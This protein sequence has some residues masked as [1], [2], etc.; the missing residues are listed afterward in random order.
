MKFQAITFN[1]L[2]YTT[3]THTHTHK[4]QQNPKHILEIKATKPLLIRITRRTNQK[5]NESV[6]ERN[7]MVGSFDS[8]QILACGVTTC[9]HPECG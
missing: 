3:H 9:S 1:F 5:A 7:T 6:T 2:N 8:A 4:R